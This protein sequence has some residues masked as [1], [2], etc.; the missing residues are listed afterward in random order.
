[1]QTASVFKG[2][3]SSSS[4]PHIIFD[5]LYHFLRLGVIGPIGEEGWSALAEALRLLPSLAPWHFDLDDPLNSQG[6]RS[7]TVFSFSR[8]NSKKLMLEGRRQ[9]VRAVFDALPVGSSWRVIQRIKEGGSRSFD[10]NSEED[11]EK[12]EHFMDTEEPTPTR[13]S[14]LIDQIMTWFNAICKWFYTSNI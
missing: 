4:Y 14:I 10:K 12:L 1:M 13:T 5:T 11:W 6:F 7:F 3:L 9:D 8:S 2:W